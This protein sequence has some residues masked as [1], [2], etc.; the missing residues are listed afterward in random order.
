MWVESCE[1]GQH[2]TTVT[3]RNL[4]QRL[5]FPQADKLREILAYDYGRENGIEI[6]I[7]GERVYR[8]EIQGA[9]FAKE[10]TLPDGKTATANWTVSEKP[11]AVRNAGI[12]LRADEKA[13]GKPH[14]W[15]LEHDDQLTDRLRNRVVG[16][17]KIESD[18]VELTAAGG[19]VIESEKI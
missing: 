17:L 12:I 10:Y 9:K 18:T 19:D 15:G 4:N 14:H 2:G 16:E 7:N 3:L 6:Y 5:N 13:I 8:H 11:V 1:I